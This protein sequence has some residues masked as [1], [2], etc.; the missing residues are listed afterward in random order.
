MIGKVLL[1]VP[2]AVV[3]VLAK[4]ALRRA[5]LCAAAA[6]LAT[7]AHAREEIVDTHKPFAWYR[8]DKVEAGNDGRLRV[9]VDASGH[10]R[11]LVP[12]P[13]APLVVEGVVNGRPVIRFKGTESTLGN[14][15]YHWSESGFSVFVVASSATDPAKPGVH[16]NHRNIA[17]PGK[18]LVSDGGLN[19]LAL[20]I[21]WS[22]R[23]G[24]I[25]RQVVRADEEFAPPYENECAS[26]I[27]IETGRFYAF[28]YDASRIFL[29][30]TQERV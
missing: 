2:D 8:A 5:L 28:A 20:G 10:G 19:C 16:P 3:K 23:P 9:L 18:V 29:D 24:A 15:K 11:N 12:G 30:R 22:G 1:F 13:E 7:H 27:L 4:K 21:N 6:I 26:D 14:P 17:T 25:S